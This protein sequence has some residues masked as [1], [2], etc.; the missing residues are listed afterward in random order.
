MA[1]TVTV[2]KKEVSQTGPLRYQITLTLKYLEDGTAA[3]LFEKDYPQE[4]L[5]GEAPSK[6]VTQWKASM[7][8]DIDKFKAQE[9]LFNQALLN[10]AVTN[11]QNGLVV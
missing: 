11:I 3:V 8:A 4:Y 9:A 1:R 10:T 2:T 7:Q 5:Y 6:Y